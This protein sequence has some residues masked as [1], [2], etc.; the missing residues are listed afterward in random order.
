[1]RFSAILSFSHS[2]TTWTEIRTQASQGWKELTAEEKKPFLDA[3]TTDKERYEREMAKYLAEHPPECDN[4]D[5]SD[6][7]APEAKPKKRKAAAAKQ[8]KEPPK[9]K[10]A[11]ARR[12]PKGAQDEEVEEQKTVVPPLVGDGEGSNEDNDESPAEE[13]P[14]VDFGEDAQEV[15]E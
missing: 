2:G 3:A 11:P 7:E 14:T 1:L 13:S 6:D 12:K 5:A 4:K 10:Q 9:K 15:E 8:K